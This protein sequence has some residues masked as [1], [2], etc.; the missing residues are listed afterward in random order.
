VFNLGQSTANDV[1]MGHHFQRESWKNIPL[2][3]GKPCF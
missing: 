3:F 1:S 2:V